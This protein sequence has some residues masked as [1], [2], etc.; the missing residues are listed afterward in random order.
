MD[1]ACAKTCPTDGN[2]LAM[3]PNCEASRR[4]SKRSKGQADESWI[5]GG[6]KDGA[7]H[8]LPYLVHNLLSTQFLKIEIPPLICII[9][10][11]TPVCSFVAIFHTS[12]KMVARIDRR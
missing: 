10:P 5:P 1:I 2:F 9:I 12:K 11:D 8:F 4:R 7:K 6:L 3:I